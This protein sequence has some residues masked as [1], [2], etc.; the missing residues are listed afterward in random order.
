MTVVGLPGG[1]GGLGGQHVAPA[2]EGQ[3]DRSHECHCR[4][5]V[6]ESEEVRLAGWW[7]ELG[8]GGRGVEVCVSA[9]RGAAGM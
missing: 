3:A 8:G 5:E 9:L 1:S 6:P 2:S 7:W 4:D